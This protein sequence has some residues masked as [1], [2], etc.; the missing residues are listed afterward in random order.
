MRKQGIPKSW[1][2][3]MLLLVLCPAIMGFCAFSGSEI[4][5][6]ALSLLAYTWLPF[7]FQLLLVQGSLH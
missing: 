1:R 2:L 4:V 6:H 3:L 5:D 7:P